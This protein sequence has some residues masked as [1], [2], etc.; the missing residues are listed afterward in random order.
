MSTQMIMCPTKV[1]KQ[2]QRLIQSSRIRYMDQS[3]TL[4]CIENQFFFQSFK[5]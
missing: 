3:A 1:A 4:D 2:Q 5:P